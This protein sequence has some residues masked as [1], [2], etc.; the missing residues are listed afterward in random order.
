L[1]KRILIANRGEIVVRVARTC[2][3]FGLEPCGIYSDADTSSL[4][5]KYCKEAVKIGGRLT[6]ESYLRMDKVIE[7]AKKMGCDLIH[8]GYGFL[9]ESLQFSR[10]CEKEG[11]IF[12]GPSSAAL[13]LSGDKARAREVAAEIAPILPGREVSTESDAQ[14]LAEQIG[15]PIILKAVKGGG[16]RGLRIVRSSD[17]LYQA[18][19]SSKNEAMISFGSNRLYIEKYLE[20]PR[21]IEVQI[22][23]DNSKVIHLGERECSV[24]RRHQKL[25]EETPSPALTNDLRQI[26]TRTAIAIMKRMNYNNAGTVEFLF[27]EGSFYFME[28]NSRIQ[29]EHPITEQVT[30]IDIVEQQLRIATGE[31]LQ[32]KQEDVKPKGHSIECRINAEHPITF[33]P[34]SGTVT[35]FLPPADEDVRIDTALYSGYS[36]PS[37][38]DSLIAK[39]ICFGDDRYKAIEKMKESLASFRIS[40]IPTTIPFHLSAL[41]DR[42]F[43][44]GN[45]DTS[46]I[47]DLKPY[48]SKEGEVAAAVLSQ[49]PRRI[50]FLA[51]EG[52]AKD[53]WMMSR[54]D[55]IQTAVVQPADYYSQSRWS[56]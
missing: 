47:D 46:F 1:V 9:A 24:Q 28:V 52:G 43:L 12:V 20:H 19:G 3:R 14:S 18:L 8:P 23:G 41:N 15:Y 54:F 30:G 56:T 26:M 33:V 32:I 53:R 22:L 21:H 37:F 55:G 38:Y 6:S 50:R 44:E 29:V 36:I 2:T 39:L 27:K 49:L 51:K 35:N 17:E 48:S 31:G 4:H 5:I 40:G 13:E 11:I 42:R 10:L 45:Y 16:G 25:I 7:A 34:F